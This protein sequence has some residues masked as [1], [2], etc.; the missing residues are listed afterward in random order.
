MSS[1]P[2]G[3]AIN[4]GNE[5]Y[6]YLACYTEA[7]SG[8]ALGAKLVAADDMTVPKCLDACIAYKYAGIE[9]R[10]ECW[11]SNSFGTGSVAVA[12]SECSMVCAGNPLN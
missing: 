7:T 5:S 10:R 6:K 9:Y 12:D 3:P 8:R 2:T 1:I 4:L 11:C